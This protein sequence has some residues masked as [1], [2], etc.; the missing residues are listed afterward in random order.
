[1]QKTSLPKIKTML[2]L[3]FD[4]EGMMHTEFVPEG[5]TVAKKFYLQV[6]DYLRKRIA[7]VRP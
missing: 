5:E 6:L 1:M 7:H 3:F 4:S 2:I